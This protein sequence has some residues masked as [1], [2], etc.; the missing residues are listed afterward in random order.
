[1]PSAATASPEIVTAAPPGLAIR[2]DALGLLRRTSNDLLP[3]NGVTLLMGTEIIFD[4]ESFSAHL[5]VPES[6]G[7]IGAC[8][9]GSRHGGVVNA[10]GGSCRT[11]SRNRH[12][13]RTGILGNG[14][15][16]GGELHF[17]VAK[18]IPAR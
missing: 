8:N 13:D 4:V 16:G 1:M 11:D 12:R 15:I 10:D 17:T 9:G 7:K 3:K 14:N 18:P 6:T 5:S 2:A